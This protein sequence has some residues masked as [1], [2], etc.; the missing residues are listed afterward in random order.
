MFTLWISAQI[1]IAGAAVLAAGESAA[2]RAAAALFLSAGA[3]LPWLTP[4][5]PLPR[6]ILAFVALI[7]FIKTT[8]I[9][10]IPGPWPMWRRLWHLFSPFHVCSTRSIR[11]GVS[12]RLAWNVILQG[13]LVILALA[14]LAE[15]GSLTGVVRT[16]IRLMCGIILLTGIMTLLSDLT[17]FGHHAV[18]IEVPPN[19]RA[20]IL[21]QSVREFWGKR[22]N[23]FV[24]EWLSQF[25]FLPMVRR[26]RPVLGLFG[27]FCVSALMHS[28]LAVV[29]LDSRAALTMG[30][31]FV[32]QGVFVVAETRLRLNTWPAP[33]ARAWTIL[34][35]LSP[36]PL[37]ID[38]FLRVFGL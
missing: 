24:S 25:I 30:M 16:V 5:R 7:A 38:P 33:A 19:Q 21:A 4:P 2:R 9:A 12:G 23:R 10:S 36:S 26:R 13:G 1:G 17:R 8:Q 28:W 14:V 32:L 20:P 27:A 3:A 22:W 11:P 35:V 31:F 34:A 37:G 18:G 15:L 6:V 29:A